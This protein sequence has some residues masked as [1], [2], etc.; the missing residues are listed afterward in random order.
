MS[1]LAIKQLITAASP[2]YV[3]DCYNFPVTEE[4]REVRIGRPFLQ[5]F[6]SLFSA[7]KP[8]ETFLEHHG[9]IVAYYKAKDGLSFFKSC[10]SG[11][12]VQDDVVL[13]A[14]HVL[15]LGKDP[16]QQEFNQFFLQNYEQQ[17]HNVHFFTRSGLRYEFSNYCLHPLYI[18]S[19]YYKFCDIALLYRPSF[20][21][22]VFNPFSLKIYSPGD[23]L[24]G[25]LWIHGYTVKEE[26]DTQTISA[27]EH[28]YCTNDYQV[29][30]TDTFHQDDVAVLFHNIQTKKGM[31]GAA[32]YTKSNQQ[33]HITAIHTMGHEEEGVTGAMKQ[34]WNGTQESFMGC[35][36]S[37][38]KQQ[39]FNKWYACFVKRQIWDKLAHSKIESITRWQPVLLSIQTDIDNAVLKF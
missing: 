8:Q 12:M 1:L 22:I 10:G 11:T 31:S 24:Q 18:S 23:N 21:G 6:S 32:L 4:V 19:Q 5:Q 37:E 35:L 33:C 9:L 20:L 28:Q 13:T 7:Q 30:F 25:Q 26:I 2:S 36:F 14:S 38:K 34:W 17:A 3:F 15:Y 27:V 16:K 39:F 29:K